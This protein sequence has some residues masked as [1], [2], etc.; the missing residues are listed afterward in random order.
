MI[1]LISTHTLRDKGKAVSEAKALFKNL[2]EPTERGKRS[3]ALSFGLACSEGGFG[4]RGAP[5]EE[6]KKKKEKQG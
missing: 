4:G 5:Q 3:C 6:R 1:I 2:K